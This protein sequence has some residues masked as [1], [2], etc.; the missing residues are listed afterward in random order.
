MKQLRDKVE[1]MSH[2]LPVSIAMQPFEIVAFSQ[3]KTAIVESQSI[4]LGTHLS[5]LRIRNF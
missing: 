2:T 3:D 5:T 1:L 4:G